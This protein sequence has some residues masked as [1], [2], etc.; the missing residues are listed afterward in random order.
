MA[1]SQRQL[2]TIATFG[3]DRMGG[4]LV[5]H[6]GCFGCGKTYSLVE[7]FGLYCYNLKRYGIKGLNFVLLGKTQSAVKKNMCNVLSKLFGDDFRYDNSKRTG[8]VKDATLFGQNLYI[9]GLADS[10]SESK[11]RGISDITGILHDEA[12]LCT[13]EQF[14]YI[15]GRLRGETFKDMPEGYLQQWYIGSTNPDVPNHFLLQYVNNGILK[16]IKWYKR[17]AKWDG[18][19]E[20]YERLKQLYKDIPSFYNR[21]V[22]GEWTSSDRMVYPMFNYK[23]HTLDNEDVVINYSK[24]K[25]NIIAIDYGS[26][27]PTAIVVISKNWNGI[28]LVGSEYKLT[29]TAPSDIVHKVQQIIDYIRNSGG[30]VDSIY[31]DPSAKALKDE[32]TK[33]NIHYKNALNSHADGIGCIRTQLVLGKLMIMSNCEN[34]ISEMYSYTYRD[35]SS[36][37]DEVNKIGDD[38][39]DALR[40]GVYSDY[41]EDSNR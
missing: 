38:F 14:D 9:I 32:M 10:S 22:K 24:V 8:I 1:H 3:T 26:D 5:L 6:S 41:V 40:Y 7:G 34:L 12:V 19:E 31:V 25:S 2:Y 35:V 29:N 16:M 15:L 28:Y 36:G 11:F 4:K 13:R 27:H 39:V 33:N 20:Y 23:L 17:D 37:K 18:A 21:Y 30:Y